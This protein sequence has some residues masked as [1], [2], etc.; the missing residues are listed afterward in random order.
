M[1]G[2][3]GPITVTTSDVVVAGA[4]S[5]STNGAPDHRR[6]RR[7]ADDPCGLTGNVPWSSAWRDDTAEQLEAEIGA[8]ARFHSSRARFASGRRERQL[9]C[10]AIAPASQP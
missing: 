9:R 10:A 6:A 8:S 5:V 1:P 3:S 2:R 4:S 7:K